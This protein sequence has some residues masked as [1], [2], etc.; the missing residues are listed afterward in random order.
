MLYDE[1]RVSCS[2]LPHSERS[3]SDSQEGRGALG[4]PLS[5]LRF[6]FLLVTEVKSHFYV[7]GDLEV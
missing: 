6:I 3:P 2:T 7:F 5:F 4:P 1:R